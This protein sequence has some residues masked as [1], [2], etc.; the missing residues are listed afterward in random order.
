MRQESI[1]GTIA[2]FKK[3]QNTGGILA[4]LGL[5]GLLAAFFLNGDHKSFWP[6]YFFGYFFWLGMTLGCVTLTFLHHTIRASWSLSMLRIIEA[7]N[8]TLP[9][10]AIFFI[11][12]LFGMHTHDIYLWSNPAE[13]AKSHVLQLKQF[14]LNPTAWSIRAVF[15]FAYWLIMTRI[16]NASSLK[17]DQTR[18][19]NLA[20]ARTN[21]SAPGGVM[22]VIL[23]TFAYTDWVMSLDPFWYSTIY[24]GWFMVTQVLGVIAFGI[25]F[26]VRLGNRKPYSEILTP[27]LTKNLGNMMLG[28]TMLWGYFSLSQ[29]LIIWSANLPEEITFYVNRFT[30]PLV[31][32][33]GFLIVAQFFIPFVSLCSGRTKRTPALLARVAGW[34]LMVRVLDIWW[35][36]TPFFRKG[37]G[38][39]YLADYALDLGAVAGFGGLWLAFFAWNLLKTRDA[40]IPLHDARLIESKQEA[41]SHA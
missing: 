7:G 5:G 13:V 6:S 23:L 11:P 34:I 35:Q 38:I 27:T 10:M 28:F 31:V 25:T 18:D 32:V 40:L 3:L 29:F 17:Q 4:F 26:V 12:I 24:G 21:I 8:K 2:V 1:S 33:G 19:E 20:I 16:L 39:Q 9:L 36:I 22:H 30:G 15:Y 41:L 37:A 14:W